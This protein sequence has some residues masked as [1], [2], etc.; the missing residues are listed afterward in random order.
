[1]TKDLPGQRNI[2]S[3]QKDRP[4]N[5]MEANNILANQVQIR[6]PVLCPKFAVVSVRIITKTGNVI[7]Q[8]IQPYIGHMLGVKGNRDS[9]AERGTGNAQILKPRKQE[10]IHHLIFPGNRLNKLRMRMNMV[11]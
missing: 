7:G 3:H 1:M 11:D 5:G 4:V 6:R 8:C 2:Q 9:P 10:V